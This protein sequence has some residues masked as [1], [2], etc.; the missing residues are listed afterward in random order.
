M[1]RLNAEQYEQI[2]T[3][4]QVIDWV[5]NGVEFPFRDQPTECFHHNRVFSDNHAAFIDSEINRLLTIGAIE[6]VLQ[7]PH[8]VLSM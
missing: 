4:P 3:S 5:K 1:Y 6:Q 8:C 7:K 2:G